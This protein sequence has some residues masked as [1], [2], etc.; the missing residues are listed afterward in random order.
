MRRQLLTTSLL[1]TAAAL[2]IAVTN[3][4]QATLTSNGSEAGNFIATGAT[5]HITVSPSGALSAATTTITTSGF[6]RIGDITDPYNGGL[7]NFAAAN[8]GTINDPLSV[9]VADLVTITQP[10]FTVVNGP[11]AAFNV[12]V[13]SYTFTF[14][15][16]H[17]ISRASG[18]VSLLFDGFLAAD[19]NIGPFQLGVGPTVTAD[20]SVTFTQSSVGGSIAGAFSIDSPPL[21]TPEPAS[22]M[23]LGAGLLGLGVA[24]RKRG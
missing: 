1:F 18:A 22:M 6:A 20:F 19:S 9:P 13:D 24:R 14:T 5:K 3:P 8:G 12:I 21:G 4:A 17:I 16:E 7:N 15:N 10:T 2:L 23:V 11:I